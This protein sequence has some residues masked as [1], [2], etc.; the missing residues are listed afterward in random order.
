M[1]ISHILLPNIT[2]YFKYPENLAKKCVIC[3]NK[4]NY[5]YPTAGHTYQGF[6]GIHN[7]I[8]RLY[9][10]SNPNCNLHS[11][12]YNPTNLN[13]LPFKRYSLAIWKW[14]GKE[15]FIYNVKPGQIHKRITDEFGVDIS[16]GT[17]RNIIKEIDTF[18]GVEI[19]KK[20]AKILKDQ[21]KILLAMDGQKPDD[22]GK[23]LW[24]FVDLISNRVVKVVLLETAD[25]ETLHSCVDGILKTYEVELVGG[26]SDKQGSIQKMRKE[27]YPGVPWQ[28]CHFH[29][30]QNLWN[31]IEIKDGNLH[32]TLKKA[33]NGLYILTT[34]KFAQVKFDGMGKMAI[35]ELFQG[36]SR[37][38]KA[39]L[40]NSTKKFKKLR[41]IKT[42][43]ELEG[44]ISE[45][46]SKLDGE[47]TS[48]RVV[49][50][51]KDVADRLRV[52]LI[53]T[54]G[55][56]ETCTK[57][58]RLLQEIKS[59]LGDN[60]VGRSEKVNKLDTR[61]GDIWE[62]V[63]GFENKV[64]ISNLRSFMPQK[65]VNE[66]KILQEWVRLYHSYK[67][68]LFAYYDFPIVVR[69]NS[70][71]EASFGCEKTILVSRSG[72]SKVG[73][74]IRVYGPGI[75]KKI[76]AGTEEV[77]LILNRISDDFDK[78][79]LQSAFEEL[80]ARISEETAMWKNKIR[81]SDEIGKLLSL[82]KIKKRED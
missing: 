58:F 71:M 52:T 5:C 30:L 2:H 50:I 36:V 15:A 23:A 3:G 32:K 62:K 40:K 69:T 33:I 34:S 14:I 1:S 7:D 35:R 74:Q 51:M 9:I 43:G 57:L 10:C 21:G 42:Y 78:K 48:R 59:D 73:S 6:D 80:S 76:Y 66:Q 41:G 12:P 44:Y 20:T 17:I 11:A 65:G 28:W 77:G 37:Q 8:L 81:K 53:E 49:K 60:K 63:K 82:G 19:D 67:S 45:M 13:V 16:E 31:H 64:E 29:F 18:L 61:F 72:K 24:L 4:V 56:N 22:K 70:A 54:K 25:H 27:F 38:L 55:Q 47:D 26:V 46:E 68:G 39:I 79:S 75:L